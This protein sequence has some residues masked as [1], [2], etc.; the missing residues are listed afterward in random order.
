[1]RRVWRKIGWTITAA[2]GVLLLLV[3]LT[4]LSANTTRGRSWIEAAVPKFTGGKVTLAQLGGRFPYR[5]HIGYLGISD[6]AG[7]WLAIDGLSLDWSPFKLLART[8]AI[9]RLEAERIAVAR[10]PAP[11]PEPEPEPK[12]KPSLPVRIALDRLQVARLELAEPVLGVAAALSVQAQAQLAALD[13]GEAGLSLRRLDG[14]GD[15][16]VKAQLGSDGIRAKLSVQEPALGLVAGL[17]QL[18]ELGAVAFDASVDGPY[19]A[20]NSRFNLAAGPLR[21]SAQGLINLDQQTADLHVS[22]TAPSMR[23]RPDLAWQSV[24]LQAEVRGPFTQPTAQAKLRIAGLAAADARIPEITAQVQGDRGALNLSATLTGIRLPGPHPELLRAAPLAV[25]ADLRLDAPALPLKFALRHPLLGA[26]GQA[27]L[28][29]EPRGEVSLKLPDLKPLAALGGQDVRGSAQLNLRGEQRSGTNQAELDAKFLVT[30]GA[31]PWPNLVGNATL[32]T[33]VK[34]RGADLNLERLDFAGKALSV[35]VNGAMTGKGTDFNWKL[36]LADLGALAP[37]LSGRAALQGRLTGPLNDLAVNTELNGELAAQGWPRGPVSAR[38]SLQGL[39]ERPAGQLTAQGT[40][41]GAPLQLAVN[42]QRSADGGLR[43]AI[44]RADWKSAH[45]EGALDMPRGATLPLGRIELRM[46]RLDDLQALLGQPLRGAVSASLDAG[47]RE[48]RLRM[49]AH[50]AGLSGG[51]TTERAELAVTVANPVQR[52]LVD[53]RLSLE[54]LAVGAIRGAVKLDAS[55]PLNALDLALSADLRELGGADARLTSA[56]QLDIPA[57]TLALESLQATW[58]KE[59]LRLLEPARIAF[60]EGLAVDRLRLGLR[61]AV[62]EVAGRAAP[63]LALDVA[64][65]QVPAELASLAVPGLGLEGSVQGE[66]H[67]TGTTAHPAG[68]VWLGAEGLRLRS[69]P[70]RA[71]PP[72]SFN[73]SAELAGTSAQIDAQFKAGALAGLTLNGLAPLEPE[74]AVD[75]HANGMVDLKLLDPLLMAQGRR[76]RGQIALN[77]GVTGTLAAPKAQGELRWSHGEVQDSAQGLWLADITALIQAEGDSL[78]I[79]RFQGKAGPGTVA[80][81]GSVGVLAPGMPV[82]VKLTAR[83]AR[84]LDSDRLTVNLDADLG[85]AGQ[86]AGP[87]RVAGA[88]RIQ[89]AEIRIPERLPTSIAVLD[90]RKPGA[91]P[92][93][94]PKPG[95]EIGLDLS[96]IAPDEIFVRGRGLFAELGGTIHL[97]GTAAE[98]RPEGRFELRRGEFSLAGQTLNFS[99]GQVGFDGGSLTDPSLDF[100]AVTTSG[101]VTATLGVGG[102]ARKPKIT[103]SSV[104]EAPPD[105]V[106]AHLLFGR[107]T[108]SLSPWEMVQIASAVASLTGITS[109]VGN[110]LETVRKGLGLDRLAIGGGTG[111]GPALEA[112]RYVAPGVFLGAKQGFTGGGTQATVQ[113]DVAKGLKLE[114]SVGTGGSASSATGASAQ[115]GTNSVGVI[116]QIEY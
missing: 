53:G 55:G 100:A 29:G 28:G 39:P 58:K 63:R 79:A 45:A 86:A 46:A 99:K 51:A 107:A 41:L 50:H 114:G 38:L 42:G 5:L 52:P 109:G 112:G 56:A 72:A 116:Y 23:L 4:G 76:T 94:P 35:S 96:I 111:G 102:T 90:V 47:E 105:E 7:P 82:D 9:T 60:G 89:R 6:S 73:A 34:M 103:L 24:D 31:A 93:P 84:P 101:N 59:S 106:L 44:E 81:N 80:L 95:P 16:E 11:S 1:M 49:E 68:V 40:V 43:V 69:G 27:T 25:Q 48:A 64:L 17:A 62:L 2:L 18:T 85:V 98:P 75:L 70:G 57:K 91:P 113:V 104:P 15:Y 110:P 8:A 83:N 12:T 66:A 97:R 77:G 32:S 30:G 21:S 88:L 67:L 74:G 115:A 108:T 37:R 10:L 92:P 36:G 71:W 13:Q 26:E 78:R 65:S 61:E 20:L 3:L 14:E 54:G 19:S 33:A 87:L 22:A